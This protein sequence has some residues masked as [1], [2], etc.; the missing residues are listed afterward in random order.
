MNMSRAVISIALLLVAFEARP[1]N[2][3]GDGL[4]T[5]HATYRVEHKG[6]V[7]GTAEISV[8]RDATEEPRYEF[9]SVTKLTGVA[10]LLV[11]NA[12]IEH[13]TFLYENGRIVP[14]EFSYEDG[15]KGQ[16]DVHLSFDWN[17]NVAIAN[18]KG[19]TAEFA[20]DASVLDRGSLQVAVMHD[21]GT[22]GAPAAEY[23]L[24]ADAALE[25]YR[26]EGADTATVAT[27][28]GPISAQRFIQRR[29]G[30]SQPLI[31]WLAPS[32]SYLP[33]RIEREEKSG[34]VT[35]LIL[36]SVAGLT[37]ESAAP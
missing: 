15:R 11:P 24:A 7:S 14:V 12:A 26:Y 4:A 36:V 16:G 21:L 25:T 29:E 30:A 6:S 17:R 9:T 10:K 2:V 34:A 19:Q 37:A 23:H 28:L 1:A 31:L 13:S 32:L 35:S 5:Y 20:V 33:V 3:A 22:G 18:A 27:G 8:R